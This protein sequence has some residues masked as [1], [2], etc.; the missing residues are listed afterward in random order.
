[1]GVRHMGDAVRKRQCGAGTRTG[2]GTRL[3][4]AHLALLAGVLSGCGG[5]SGNASGPQA[6]PSASASGRVAAARGATIGGPG[7][8]CALPVTFTLA[9][10]WKAVAVDTG[11][12][13]AEAGDDV[14]AGVLEAVLRQGPVRAACEADAKP[15]GH[16]GFLRVWTGDGGGD[17]ARTVLEAFVAA[18]EHTSG[19]RYRSFTS[20]GL[21]GAEVAYRYG[22]GLPQGAKPERALAVVTPDGPVVLHLGGLDGAEFRA[23]TPAFELARD[24]LRAV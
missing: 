2:R 16:I 5:T 1:M 11:R 7:S 6:S 20:G 13:T 21:T 19:A 17:G 24:T 22:G 23:M 8:A 4:V 14:D 15:A 10:R 12:L 18:Q 9:E 3:G